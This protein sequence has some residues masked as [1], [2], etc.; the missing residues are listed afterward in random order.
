MN[1]AVD[2][3]LLNSFS[4][5]C[6]FE[7]IRLN[8]FCVTFTIR[9]LFQPFFELHES[10]APC[11]AFFC[12][13][14]SLKLYRWRIVNFLWRLMNFKSLENQKKI[15]SWQCWEHFQMMIQLFSCRFDLATIIYFAV[16]IKLPILFF[17]S[18]KCFKVW[19]AQLTPKT[20]S[21]FTPLVS[22][23]PNVLPVSGEKRSLVKNKQ[24]Q[25]LFYSSYVGT[26][27]LLVSERILYV[28]LR[29]FI[30][31]LPDIITVYYLLIFIKTSFYI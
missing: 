4:T 2:A 14:H 8:V 1:I 11:T 23:M 15:V 24:T 5:L 20:W 31:S 22:R 29:T 21:W 12:K 18:R 16:K 30:Y 13:F 28:F 6:S 25:Q 7:A 10:T 26:N 3:V 27:R 17:W 9:C 19:P